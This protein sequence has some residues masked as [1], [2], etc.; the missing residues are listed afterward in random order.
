[1]R[2]VPPLLLSGLLL[3]AAA[4]A[5]TPAPAAAPTEGAAPASPAPS[6]AAP[7]SSAPSLALGSL[8]DEN[9]VAALLWERAPEF[10]NARARVLSARAD[11]LRSLQ[12][13]NP[14]MD[15]DVGTFPVGPT[16]PPDLNRWTAVANYGVGLSELIELGKRGPRQDSARAALESAALDVQATLRTRTYDVLERAAEVATAQVRLAQLEHLATDAARLTELQ[17]ARAEH[18]EAAGL[19]VERSVLEEAQLQS[20]LA[21]ETSHLAEALLTCSQTV[22]MTCTPFADGEAASHF[23]LSRLTPA[24]PPVDTQQ[25]P[26]LRSLEAQERSAHSAHLLAQR[27]WIPDPTLHL[28][29]LRDQFLD[30]GNQRDSLNLSLTFPLPFFDHGQA[31]ALAASAAAEAASRARQQL[32]AQAERDVASFTARRDALE[33]RRARVHQQILPQATTLVERM[34]AAMKAGG[35]SLQDLLFARRTYGQL[36]LDA[37]DL[38]LNAF[39]LSI[40]LERLRAAGP[41][42]P[43]ELREFIPTPSH[44]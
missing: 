32:S 27:H 33:A 40:G 44:S 42:P 2:R 3:G 23:L 16:N 22:G 15:L 17:R 13:P 8:P 14:Q 37:A 12:L 21:E 26:D 34:E 36:L 35:T 10:A 6:A 31:D 7:A 39:R 43:D 25:R 20:Q 9:G 11:L 30:A 19:D 28:G 29:Y 4:S 1:M 18:G 41:Q 38:D 24:P 5:Q